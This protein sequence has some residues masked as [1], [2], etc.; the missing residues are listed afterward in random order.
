[1]ILLTDVIK[2]IIN[3]LLKKKLWKKMLKDLFFIFHKKFLKTVH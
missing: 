3:E 1:M 2:A